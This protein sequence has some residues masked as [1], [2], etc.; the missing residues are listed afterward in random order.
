MKDIENKEKTAK[1]KDPSVDSVVHVTANY[2]STAKHKNF[3]VEVSSTLEQVIVEAYDKL[4]QERRPTDKFFCSEDPRHDL[5]PHL[6]KTLLQMY[7]Q[8]I[9]VKRKNN[10]LEFEFDIDTDLGGAAE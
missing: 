7:E 10:K 2:T 5:A 1:D 9:C 8:G 3:N 4:K 6:S